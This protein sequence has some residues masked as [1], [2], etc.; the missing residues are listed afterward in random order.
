MQ[1]NDIM[2]RN[3]GWLVALSASVC[4]WIGCP[5]LTVN[6]QDSTTSLSF[7]TD[8]GGDDKLPWF[9]LKPGEFPPI[10]AAHYVSGELISLDHVNRTGVLRPD[11]TDAQRRGDWDLPHAFTLLP[12]GSLSY[13]G[14]PADLKDIPLG[15]HLHGWFYL[16]EPAPKNAQKATAKTFGPPK[17]VSLEAPFNRCF[18]LE[19]DLSFHLRQDRVWR[20][21]S[22]NTETNTLVVTGI[23]SGK[24][25]AKSTAFQMLGATRVWRGRCVVSPSDIQP[26]SQLWLNLTYCTLKGPGRVVSMWLDSDSRELARTQQLEVHRQFQRE[27]GL[28]GWVE[29]VDNE[30]S[31]L[32]VSLFAGFDPSLKTAFVVNESIT[33]AV[34]E[35][36]LRTWD[37]INDRKSGTL[38]EV[39]TV[40]NPPAGHSGFRVKLKPSLLLEGFRPK[41]VVRLWPA[42]WKVDDLP[43]EE[44]LYQ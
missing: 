27:H 38:L 32:W 19:D 22:L 29:E 39:Q 14:A 41:R 26:G 18:R 42:S 28:A 37:Q 20:V 11:R 17:R 24:A 35:E 10:G 36:N 43:R 23:T 21:E 7:R 16:E 3:L 13:H 6:A 9:Q 25:D 1:R 40:K 34:A 8:G 33:A 15:T 2:T 4:S 31:T 30:Q 44:R 12:F 5:W